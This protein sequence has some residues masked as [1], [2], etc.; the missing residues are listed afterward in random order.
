LPN[1]KFSGKL[2]WFGSA[3]EVRLNWGGSATAPIYKGAR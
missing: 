3:G 1:G 2:K